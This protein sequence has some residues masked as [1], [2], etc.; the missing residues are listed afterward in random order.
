M[1]PHK[2]RLDTLTG[3]RFYAAFVVLARHAV[4]EFFNAPVL[5]QLAAIGPIGVGFFFTL[6]GFILTWTWKPGGSKRAFYGRRFAR[7]Y[8]LHLLTTAIAVA[9]LIAAGTPQWFSDVLSVLLLQAWGPDTWRLGG[10]GPS[11]SLSVEAFF[12]LMF[13][14]IVP[15][16][17]RRSRRGCVY[18]AIATVG[19]MVVWTGLYAVG[20]IIDV[21]YVTA[22]SPYTNPLYR[23]GEF[24]IGISIAVAMKSGW[25]IRI[26]FQAVGR[27]G[28]LG[29][30][31]LASLNAVVAASGISL[32]DTEGLPLGVLDLMFL[33]ITCLLIAG[34]ASADLR[35]ERTGLNG[36]WHVRLGEWS[37]ALYLV[38]MLVIVP[39]AAMGQFNGLSIGGLLTLA[40]VLMASQVAA[41]ALFT[42]VERPAERFLRNL[43]GAERSSRHKPQK[44]AKLS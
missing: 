20:S 26:S 19:T 11:W 6:S 5:A 38:Q 23:L 9:Y 37:F 17:A 39:V 16:I 33:P 44:A 22:A 28:V 2:A 34:A 12:Y 29:Y 40:A 18:I 31:V 43:L 24:V 21:P 14:F 36:T 1:E 42:W 25:R 27:I 30:G 8:P 13:P 10:N 4:P 32:G 41:A 15:A 7:V 35:G 3:L